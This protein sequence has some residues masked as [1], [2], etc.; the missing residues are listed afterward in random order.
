MWAVTGAV[1]AVTS[2]MDAVQALYGLLHH[3]C[4]LLQSLCMTYMPYV[5]CYGR[6]A[7]TVV[8]LGVLDTSL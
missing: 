5:G 4:E 8:G 2:S 7:A 3:L 6:V 1:L